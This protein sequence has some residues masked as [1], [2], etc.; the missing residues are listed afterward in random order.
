MY[1]FNHSELPEVPLRQFRRMCNRVHACHWAMG[2]LR[3]AGRLSYRRSLNSCNIHPPPSLFFPLHFYFLL[4]L[5]RERGGGLNN[6]SRPSGK[7]KFR[8]PLAPRR[9][10]SL[11]RSLYGKWLTSFVQLCVSSL[12]RNKAREA[13]PRF[14]GYESRVS[15]RRSLKSVE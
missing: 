4:L 11:A 6:T 1:T 2:V 13:P 8:G 14:S 9:W 3:W 10:C 12:L 7:L 5:L 15:R